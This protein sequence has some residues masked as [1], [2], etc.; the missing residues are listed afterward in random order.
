MFPRN[1][2]RLFMREITRADIPDIYAF[3]SDPEN[4]R[5]LIWGPATRREVRAF[6]R[7]TETERRLTPRVRWSVALVERCSLELIG[8]CY[9]ELLRDD[10][11]VAR[12][13]CVIRRQSWRQGFADEVTDELI[14]FAFEDLGAQ[15]LI[16]TSSPENTGSI[17]NLQ[18]HGLELQGLVPNAVAHRGHTRDSLLFALN[19]PA[20]QQ[21]ECTTPIAI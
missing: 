7:R 10:P 4:T 13:G 12:M 5:Y 14:R 16:A 21:R 6:V 3:A 1:T 2:P 19:N 18:K 11:T 17:H 15:Q 8:I 9:I 20:W